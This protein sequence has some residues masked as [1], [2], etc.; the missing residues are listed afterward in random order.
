MC[1]KLP[2][3]PSELLS[4]PAEHLRERSCAEQY[5]NHARWMTTT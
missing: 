4:N 1:Q 3:L 5:G 2:N